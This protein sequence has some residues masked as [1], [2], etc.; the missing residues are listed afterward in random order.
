MGLENNH[1]ENEQTCARF[2]G[3]WKLV[4]LEKN[5]QRKRAR[6]LVFMGGGG[7]WA[8][9]TTTATENKRV[10]SF[11]RVVDVGGAKV[12]AQVQPPPSRTSVFAHS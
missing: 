12:S 8:W 3:W 10:C 1:H 4:V 2:R 5:C 7:Q 11:S 6:M 9:T